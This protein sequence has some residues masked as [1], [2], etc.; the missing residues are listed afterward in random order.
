[1]RDFSEHR[2]GITIL[3]LFDRISVF[4]TLMPYL[5][6]LHEAPMQ[7]EGIP[8][9]RL[10]WTDDPKWCLEKD[11]NRFLIIE[12][13]FLKPPIADLELLRKLRARY[14]RIFFLNGNAGGAIHRPE[15]LPYVDRFYNKAV[16]A[17]PSVYTTPLY[18]TELFT[19]Y[20]HR[21]FG[22]DDGAEAWNT[23]A[24]PAVETGKIHLHWNIGVG[25]FP[26][27]HFRQRAGVAVSRGGS[28]RFAAPLIHRRESL[29]PPAPRRLDRHGQEQPGQIRPESGGFDINARLGSPGYPTIAFHRS[30]LRSVLEAAATRHRWSVAVDRVP[31][32]RYF[33]DM[34]RSIVTFSPFGWGELCFRDFEAV[35]AGSLL[36]KPDMGHLKTWPD[37]FLP[38]RTYVPVAW[39]G[40]DLEEKITWCLEHDGER[41][42]II[43]AAYEQYRDE[44]AG[45]PDRAARLLVDLIAE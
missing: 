18:G 35:R 37:I 36:L 13:M 38:G 43:R 14:D 42:T 17:D 12:R 21:E 24:V 3:A 31:V 32:K 15:V 5:L 16:F 10:R 1:M 11:R 44:L 41:E 40:S 25:D 27:R 33:S 26:R 8:L 2:T 6:G 19:D 30:H 29:V 39:D 9:P 4:H 20:Y 45:L 34:E 28:P 23:A 7:E 22:V